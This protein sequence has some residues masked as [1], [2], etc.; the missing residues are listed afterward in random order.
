MKFSK[1][2][3]L[4][5]AATLMALSPAVALTQN[6]E[7]VFAASKKAARN[8][9]KTSVSDLNLYN[10]KGKAYTG[11]LK[12]K[13]NSTVKTYN[14]P[15]WITSYTS[16]LNSDN[17]PVTIIKNGQRYVWLGEQGLYQVQMFRQY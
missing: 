9:I 8:T 15:V 5:S 17:F 2:V 3:V 14:K 16:L 11:K 10:S 4:V 6:N 7:P 13:S 1:K 12:I